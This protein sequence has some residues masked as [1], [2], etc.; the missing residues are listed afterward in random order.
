MSLR[1][2]FSFRS[3][4]RMNL[5]NLNKSQLA[6]KEI[7]SAFFEGL[8]MTVP[9]YNFITLYRMMDSHNPSFFSR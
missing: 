8:A 1:G 5:T 4:L 2:S 6:H 3:N 9:N 7:A